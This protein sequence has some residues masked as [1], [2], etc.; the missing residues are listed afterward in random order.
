LTR[1]FRPRTEARI[2][3]APPARAGARIHLEIFTAS[4]AAL[5]AQPPLRSPPTSPVSV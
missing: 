3:V 5:A 4:P 2:I 1:A